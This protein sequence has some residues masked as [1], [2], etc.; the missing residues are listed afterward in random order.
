MMMRA[1]GWRVLTQMERCRISSLINAPMIELADIDACLEIMPLREKYF[2][3][4]MK[5]AAA[6]K[7]STDA[8]KQSAPGVLRRAEEPVP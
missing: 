4:P 8:I 7:L 2:D 3:S 1:L 5:L 6:T